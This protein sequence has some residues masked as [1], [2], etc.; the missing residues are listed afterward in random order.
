MIPRSLR[1]AAFH[2]AAG[3]LATGCG[4]GYSLLVD[5]VTAKRIVWL[6]VG[7]GVSLGFG[8]WR[9]LREPTAR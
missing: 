9:A 6:A 8:V 2:L 4:A 7:I 3:Y 1:S 5:G